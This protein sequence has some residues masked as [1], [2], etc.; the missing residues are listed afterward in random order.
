MR[1][2][3]WLLFFLALFPASARADFAGNC[4]PHTVI[5]GPL[6]GQP[7]APACRLL[8]SSDL[9]Q[10]N[11]AFIN[12]LPVVCDGFTDVGLVINQSLAHGGAWILPNGQCRSSITILVPDNANLYGASYVSVPNAGSVILCALSVSPCVQAGAGDN[13]SVNVHGFQIARVSGTVPVVAVGL[14]INASNDV[15]VR[16]VF[17]YHHAQP[18]SILNTGGVLGIYA[19]LD[20]VGTC[21]TTDADVVVSGV[22]G[23]YLYN[24]LLGCAGAF[25][26]AHA[27]FV[28]ITGNWDATKGTVH[29][30][31]NHYNLG[32]NTVTCAVTFE[33]FTGTTNAILDVSLRG[34]HIETDQN[35]L[36]TDSTVTGLTTV[37]IADI[38]IA[39]GW[40]GTNHIFADLS[41]SLAA[42]LN[43]ATTLNSFS[44]SNAEFTGFTD[45][46]LAPTV[47]FND[48]KLNG[49]S[50]FNNTIALTGAG[51][52]T[53][54][55]LNNSYGGNIVLSGS[56]GTA[57]VSG[58]AQAGT[59]INNTTAGSIEADIPGVGQKSF[60]NCS[61]NFG[62]T[63][64]GSSAGITY[65]VNTPVCQWQLV[66]NVVTV[67][68]YASITSIG[69]LTG[70]LAFSG[71][72]Y[73]ASSSNVGTNS[74]FLASGWTGV[75][76]GCTANAAAAGKII[77][78]Y[79]A[80]SGGNVT[81]TNSNISPPA[82]IYGTLTYPVGLTP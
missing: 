7:A 71:L 40:G 31:N 24:S 79:Q 63:V 15:L 19:Y 64:G 59:F 51:S 27:A 78:L 55:L 9:P 73:T 33:G 45:L 81:L 61:S 60:T 30:L 38:W 14:Q 36:C 4:D 23:V 82:V 56:Y 5:A 1:R 34:G 21:G 72:P 26:V 48:V 58:N 17:L 54:Q 12:E 49:N 65:T 67:A 28:R 52:S 53:L 3:L 70:A 76:G 44:I 10:S 32:L 43:P 46:T 2:A 11:N 39:G 18:I 8:N 25:D 41:N 37:S 20:H 66:G 16:D 42:G 57:R 77:N 68:Y 29:L 69:G 47:Q 35:F 62:L 50:F 13:G 74:C 6:S 80:S 75:G 22:P